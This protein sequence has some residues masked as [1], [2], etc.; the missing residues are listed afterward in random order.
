MK[1]SKVNMTKITK[2]FRANYPEEAVVFITKGGKV[3]LM[4]NTHKSPRHFFKVDQEKALPLMDDLKAVIHSHCYDGTKDYEVSPLCPSPSDFNNQID[5]G[6]PWAIMG[7]TQED[8]CELLWF[9]EPLDVPLYGRVFMYGVLDCYHFVRSYYFQNKGITLPMRSG[10][11][12]TEPEHFLNSCITLLEESFDDVSGAEPVLGDLLVL[13]DVGGAITHFA[14]YV[15]KD[16]VGHHYKNK[17]SKTDSYRLL[18]PF[19]STTYR[20][21]TH[22]PKD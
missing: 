16:R 17:V 15:G 20:L 4:E 8:E 6:V 18:R 2:H 10:Y 7:V 9:P 13:K 12:W 1:I 19:I 11:N 3:H 14:V 5:L 21:K 22:E